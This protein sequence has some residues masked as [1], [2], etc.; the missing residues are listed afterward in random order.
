MI[1]KSKE[2]GICYNRRQF[3][4]LISIVFNTFG[5]KVK[6]YS[7]PQQIQDTVFHYYVYT[8]CS[9]TKEKLAYIQGAIEAL[10]VAI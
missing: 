7:L 4:L 2:I 8:D 9:I 3:D 1:Q 6:I 5:A 10:R